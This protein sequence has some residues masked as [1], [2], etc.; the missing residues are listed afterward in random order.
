LINHSDIWWQIIVAKKTAAQQLSTRQQTTHLFIV[1]FKVIQ[2]QATLLWVTWWF[3]HNLQ[4][5][6]WQKVM[7]PK[8]TFLWKTRAPVYLKPH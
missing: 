3:H 6:L 8:L 5:K 4:Y 2:H 1:A 7:P